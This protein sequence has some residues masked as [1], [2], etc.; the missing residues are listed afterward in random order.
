MDQSDVKMFFKEA[1]DIDTL[2]MY[3][4]TVGAMEV[5]GLVPIAGAA[6]Q[7]KRRSDAG[8]TRSG[9]QETQESLTISSSQ[10]SLSGLPD[11]DHR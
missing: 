8:Q 1:S 11:E 4:W 7:R 9:Q 6:P 5:R 2:A 3:H 10:P